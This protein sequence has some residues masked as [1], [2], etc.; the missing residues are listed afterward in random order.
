MTK[1][2]GDRFEPVWKFTATTTTATILI[3]SGHPNDGG[4][5]VKNII[6]LTEGSRPAFILTD[7]D[8][9]AEKKVMI[10]TIENMLDD[11][12]FMIAVHLLGLTV[13]K[14]TIHTD[15]IISMY[16]LFD[17]DE[18]AEL[19]KNV[20]SQMESFN[21]KLTFNLYQ[22]STLLNFIDKIKDYPLDYEITTTHSIRE[23]SM[24]NPQ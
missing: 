4:I 7:K 24:W 12:Y 11:V 22:D 6:E 10:P 13:T 8:S 15:D 18:R 14:K 21:L 19:Y 1:R 16:D 5:E 2:L 17:K 23:R 3:G 20:K 9:S